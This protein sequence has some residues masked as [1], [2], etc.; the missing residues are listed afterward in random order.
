M[1]LLF[2]T[3]KCTPT[4]NLFDSQTGDTMRTK[5]Q[6]AVVKAHNDVVKQMAL[7]F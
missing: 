6:A 5:N 2:H 4:F 1:A 3:Q 7:F